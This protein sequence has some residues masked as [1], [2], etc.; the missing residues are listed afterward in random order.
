LKADLEQVISLT[1]ELINAN[2][3]SALQ[4]VGLIT[5]CALLFS[6]VS[7]FAIIS[8]FFLL[9]YVKPIFEREKDAK[10]FRIA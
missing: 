7:I 5:L 2:S 8:V 3:S 4:E 9:F 1:E 6:I 10:Y